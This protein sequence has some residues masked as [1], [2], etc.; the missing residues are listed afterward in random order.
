[1]TPTWTLET[2]TTP[3]DADIEALH[4]GLHAHNLAQLGPDAF[5]HYEAASMANCCGNGST[6]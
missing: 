4:V 5:N 6:S 2:T 3:S 1:M